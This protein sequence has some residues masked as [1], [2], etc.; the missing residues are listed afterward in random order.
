MEMRTGDRVRALITVNGEIIERIQAQLQADNTI[1]HYS[2]NVKLNKQ[3]TEKFGTY[4]AEQHE[5]QR[6]CS[7]IIYEW[8]CSVPFEEIPPLFANTPSNK[9]SNFQELVAYQES[10]TSLFTMATSWLGEAGVESMPVLPIFFRNLEVLQTCLG[11]V[12]GKLQPNK[13]RLE[14]YQAQVAILNSTLNNLERDPEVNVGRTYELVWGKHGSQ[15]QITSP[16]TAVF[17]TLQGLLGH[18]PLQDGDMFQVEVTFE[19]SAYTT[20]GVATKEA[21]LEQQVGTASSEHTY[22][23][24]LSHTT[25]R[26]PKRLSNFE[27]PTITSGTKIFGLKVDLKKLT[28]RLYVDGADIGEFTTLPAN[29]ELYPI[30]GHFRGVVT[31]L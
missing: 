7:A 16:K 30:I 5:T 9:V 11:A 21:I 8:T 26:T 18:H 1:S 19:T 12:E 25:F 14:H 15:V 17:P 29:T 22:A 23:Y 10:L 6:A 4:T 24:Q 31:A 3:D 13:S 20:I 27:C 2:Y 28:A